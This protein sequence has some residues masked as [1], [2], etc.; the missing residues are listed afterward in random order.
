[1][2]EATEGGGEVVSRVKYRWRVWCAFWRGVW[3]GMGMIGQGM[4]TIAEGMGDLLSGPYEAPE[5]I[6][7]VKARRL[8]SREAARADLEKARE[9]LRA[10]QGRQRATQGRQAV[11]DRERQWDL[12]TATMYSF[13]NMP[14]DE[15]GQ[16]QVFTGVDWGT[17]TPPHRASYVD[18]RPMDQQQ[19]RDR[20]ERLR[21]MG[22]SD[23]EIEGLAALGLPPFIEILFVGMLLQART[24]VGVRAYPWWRDL[25]LKVRPAS[26]AAARAAYSKAML[27]AHPDHG[28]TAE[29]MAKVRAAWERAQQ[30]YPESADQQ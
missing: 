18:G 27:K 1:M 22:F 9:R 17:F 15:P 25:G 12:N 24:K 23:M 26:R 19:R 5:E 4:G 16:E 30:E 8:W 13:R 10:A 7:G 29:T 20:R 14:R 11:Q 3:R 2:G 21:K 6:K 28:G